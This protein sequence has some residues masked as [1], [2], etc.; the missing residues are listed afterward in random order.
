LVAENAVA[1]YSGAAFKVRACENSVRF[2][3]FL[4]ESF[5]SGKS[6]PEVEQ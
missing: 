6:E 3:Y 1:Q 5:G 2:G 4:H